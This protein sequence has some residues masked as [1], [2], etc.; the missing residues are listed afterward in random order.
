MIKFE[1]V[2][3]FIVIERL[4]GKGSKVVLPDSSEPVSDDIFEVLEVGPGDQDHEQFLKVGDI[5]C[6]TGYINTF[7]YKGVKAILARARDVLAVVR[8]D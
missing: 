2:K 5:I 7:S 3:D 8:E 6:L 4:I 1:P